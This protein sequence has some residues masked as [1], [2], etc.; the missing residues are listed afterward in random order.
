MTIVLPPLPPRMARLPLDA[1]GYPVPWFVPWFDAAGELCT[2]GT[3]TPNFHT[4][5]SEKIALAALAG[6]CWICGGRLGT[7][8]S[9]VLGP[10]CAINRVSSEPPSHFEC[11]TFAAKAC[12]FLTRPKMRRLDPEGGAAGVMDPRNPGVALVWTTR[13]FRP[14][15]AEVGN[16]GTLFEVGKPEHVEWYAEGRPATRQEVIDS[17]DGGLPKLRRLAELDGPEAVAE[18]TIRC[19]LAMRLVPAERVNNVTDKAKCWTCG[20]MVRPDFGSEAAHVVGLAQGLFMGAMGVED[21]RAFARS[22]L[23]EEHFDAMFAAVTE[24][25]QLIESEQEARAKPKQ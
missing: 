24:L 14:F 22:T 6:I 2:P 25:S 19:G 5:T 16:P 13:L 12:P 18:L 7:F 23:C 10:M 3:G 20:A 15:R 11:A 9:F 21:G 17:I 8:R 1:R 4:V